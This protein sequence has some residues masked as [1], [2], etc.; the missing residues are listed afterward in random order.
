[1]KIANAPVSYGVFGLARED[2]P[3]PNGE[4]LL[5]Y[6]ADAGYEG[7]DLGA[8]GLLGRKDNL[9]GRLRQYGLGL[10]GGW[11]D[12][13]FGSGTDEEFDSAFAQAEAIMP[14]FVAGAEAGN[15]PVPKPT[16]ADSGDDRRRMKP[17]GSP[18]LE[19]T[20]EKW[21]RFSDRLARVAKM[22]R[23]FD[24]EPTFHHHASTYVETPSE[25]DRFLEIGDVDFTFDTGHLL[26]GGG[27]P[28]K[29]LPRWL[30]R[31][32][33]FHLK[34]ADRSILATAMGSDNPV[35]DVWEKRVFT[36]LGEGDLDVDGIMEL[37]VASG[38]DEW[39]VVEQDVVLKDAADVERAIQDQVANRDALRKWLP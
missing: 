17:G 18:E 28:I 21:E 15:F 13:P 22:V 32:N 4:E 36:P 19:L 30:P 39:L 38:F 6:V 12:L 7:I 3:L 14:L 16:L 23:G 2:T 26:I 29:D 37:I 11:V 5:R 31:I 9:A 35:R 33:H 20:D 10:A 25:I 1:M 24:L 8:P 27:D 34:D